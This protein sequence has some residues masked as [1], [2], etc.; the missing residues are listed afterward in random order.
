VDLRWFVSLPRFESIVHRK[1]LFIGKRI[2][3]L[4]LYLFIFVSFI[5]RLVQ[6]KEPSGRR[7]GVA[8]DDDLIYDLTSANAHFTSIH[9]L[10]QFALTKRMTIMGFLEDWNQ[11]GEC[12]QLDYEML[13]RRPNGFLPAI[14]H[15]GS[16]HRCMVSGSDGTHQGM[17]IVNNQE[18]ML[19]EAAKRSGKPAKGKRR[20]LLC[21]YVLLTII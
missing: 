16:P 19:M 3:S 17:T 10:F 13:W 7:L 6:W 1:L 18:E 21:V 20:H 11:F 9:T 8:M 4:Y 15:P 14:D 5:Q 12:R 2:I